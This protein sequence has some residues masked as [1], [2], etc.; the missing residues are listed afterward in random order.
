MKH[1]ESAAEGKID[2]YRRPPHAFDTAGRMIYLPRF[3]L[4]G[5]TTGG[6]SATLRSEPARRVAARL[7]APKRGAVDSSALAGAASKS[8]R[9][10]Y[11]I[12]LGV[13]FFKICTLGDRRVPGE[14]V[15]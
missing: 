12:M 10:Q 11:S 13:A 14:C 2:R 4:A 5:V 3:V 8:V 6:A 9:P 1:R 7:E 15:F